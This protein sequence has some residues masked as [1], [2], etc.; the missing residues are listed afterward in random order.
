MLST[1]NKVDIGYYNNAQDL[2]A[3]V[4]NYLSN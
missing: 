3:N 2:K 1:I 4:T